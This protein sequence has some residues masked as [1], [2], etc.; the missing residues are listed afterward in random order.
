MIIE[1]TKCKARLKVPDDEIKSE[2]S[3]FK[4]P[5]CKAVLV[6]K[7]PAVTEKIA[8]KISRQTVSVQD[9]KKM[10]GYIKPFSEKEK[11][12]TNNILNFLAVLLMIGIISSVGTLIWTS[13]KIGELGGPDHISVLDNNVYIHF[14]KTLYHL[15]STGKL[16]NS[17][18]LSDLGIKG[19]SS[20]I[21]LL[22]D[23]SILIGDWYNHDIKRCNTNTLSCYVIAPT[24]DKTLELP[25]KFVAD[26]SSGKIY[27]IDTSRHQLLVQDIEGKK[28]IVLADSKIL[29]FP[30]DLRLD[31]NLIHIADTNHHRIV[32]LKLDGDQAKEIETPVVGSNF[33]GRPGQNW[34]VALVK[35]TDGNWWILNADTTMKDA[36]LIIYDKSGEPKHRVMLPDNADPLDIALLGKQI[37]LTDFRLLKVYKIDPG[38]RNVSIF[39][40]E[41]FQAELKKLDKHEHNYKDITTIAFYMLAISVG[42]AFAL[43]ATMLK[44]RKIKHTEVSKPAISRQDS[45][46]PSKQAYSMERRQLDENEK[47]I[48]KDSMRTNWIIWAAMLLSLIVYVLICHLFKDDL[49]G[50][51]DIGNMLNNLKYVLFAVALVE[52]II[53]FFMRRLILTNTQSIQNVTATVQYTSALIISFALAES[54]G[55][56]GL[57][58]FFLGSDFETL[59]I[60]NAIAGLAMIIH[61]PKMDELKGLFFSVKQ[62]MLETAK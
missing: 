19:R 21:Q 54:I 36:D 4:C 33:L 17:I 23:G 12:K 60:F 10:Q 35:S 24:G 39:G 30:N 22:S 15:D 6:V 37:I 58:L 52:F 49:W 16:L 26:E 61:R 27:I 18:K 31:G 11:T 1:C 50:V 5:K 40:D 45:I 53:I 14:N 44:N 46:S 48:L 38:N 59:Y 32:T 2:G 34:P 29:R 20:D 3:K 42:V 62:K 8:E 51:V 41:A 9:D 13:L 57:V 55:I 28:M 7:K 56:Y 43:F 47:E 25:F